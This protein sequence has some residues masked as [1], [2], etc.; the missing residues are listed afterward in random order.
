MPAEVIAAFAEAAEV[1]EA[2]AADTLAKALPGMV[3]AVTPTAELSSENE[4]EDLY[5]AWLKTA[6]AAV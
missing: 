4:I 5:R 6:V 1:P 3:D 2:G